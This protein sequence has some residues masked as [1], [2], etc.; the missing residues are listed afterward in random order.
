MRGSLGEKIGEGVSADVHVWAPGQ[1]LKLFKSGVSR[2]L[3]WHEV[4]MIHA[5][6][7]AG[8]EDGVGHVRL[9]PAEPPRYAGLE[10]FHDLTWRPGVNVRHRAFADLLAQGSPHR[11][12]SVARSKHAAAGKNKPIDS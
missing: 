5:V 11:P 10:Q 12:S 6:F 1:V 2:R 9:V 8:A 4:H 7:A 3:S